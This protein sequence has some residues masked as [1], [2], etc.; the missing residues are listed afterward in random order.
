M[1]EWLGV[2]E[3]VDLDIRE[4]NRLE[5]GV[6]WMYLTNGKQSLRGGG[7]GLSLLVSEDEGW[8]DGGGG[9]HNSSTYF[10]SGAE[11]LGPRNSNEAVREIKSVFLW[12]LM[13]GVKL[14]LDDQ[15]SCPFGTNTSSK[16]T[17]TSLENINYQHYVLYLYYIIYIADG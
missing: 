9:E 14:R 12:M 17:L 7:D 8:M 15:C 5:N 16:S 11:R 2:I 13:C 6:Q 4:C 1:F 10:S 3:V